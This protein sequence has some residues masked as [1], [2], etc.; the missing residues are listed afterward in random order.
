MSRS[1]VVAELVLLVLLGACN[2]ALGIELAERDTD[3]DGVRDVDDNCPTVWNPDQIDSEG[4]GAGDACSVCSTPLDRDLDG[5]GFDDGCDLCLGPGLIGVDADDDGIDDGCDPCVNGVSSFDVDE[6]PRDGIADGCEWCMG[7]GAGIDI[8]G[9][10][11]DDACDP[12]LNGPPHDEDGDGIHDAC[13]NCPSVFNP[14]QELDFPTNRRGGACL[15]DEGPFT[16][17]FDPF[18]IDRPGAWKGTPPAGW[19]VGADRLVI[20]ATAGPVGRVTTTPETTSFV[21]L[22]RVELVASAQSTVSITAITTDLPTPSTL[23]CTLDGQ[24]KL[25]AVTTEP[26]QPAGL[27]SV[28]VVDISGP[29]TLKMS[30]RPGAGPIRAHLLCSATGPDAR[31]IETVAF[32]PIPDPSEG[33][34]PGLAAA[35]TTG[36]FDYFEVAGAI[37]NP[38]F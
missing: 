12:C 28:T 3:G 20:D 1:S 35:F 19:Q 10:G 22:T 36:R 21:A 8:D 16:N 7:G 15:F 32:L 17:L 5:D 30:A 13:D 26:G 37:G 24:G 4:G 23:A 29:V 6:H 31:T 38:M 2:S 14:G 9:D 18:L 11:L 34:F 27:D 33:W 25:S